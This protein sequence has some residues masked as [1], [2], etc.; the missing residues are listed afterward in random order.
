M[1]VSS[2]SI[3]AQ[4][5]WWP[6]L[7]I[8]C[9]AL[10]HLFIYSWTFLLLA[11]SRTEGGEVNVSN[12]S[13]RWLGLGIHCKR[14]ELSSKVAVHGLEHAEQT[15]NSSTHNCSSCWWEI[16]ETD[17]LR[18]KRHFLCLP[19]SLWNGPA[20]DILSAR[21]GPLSFLKMLFRQVLRNVQNQHIFLPCLLSSGYCNHT[22][23]F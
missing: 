17:N 5:N 1:A 23:S 21:R 2:R 13:G 7:L 3:E 9:L 12:V 18:S 20:Q 15:D 4:N 6:P 14:H 11:K 22:N 16:R 19:P 8:I 10:T